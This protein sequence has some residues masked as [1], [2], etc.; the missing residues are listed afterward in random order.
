MNFPH[1]MPRQICWWNKQPSITIPSLTRASS[2][3][4]NYIWRN[5]LLCNSRKIHCL[6]RAI[7]DLPIKYTQLIWR[8]FL[9]HP[10]DKR[11][12]IETSLRFGFPKTHV[13]DVCVLLLIFGI[14]HYV[15]FTNKVLDFQ[16]LSL[17][18]FVLAWTQE[19]KLWRFLTFIDKM[20]IIT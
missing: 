8:A 15:R 12:A 9:V 18:C 7:S 17:V 11:P 14:Q 4:P 10:K 5:K 3:P 16:S 6:T 2:W 19:A 1:Q 13:Q 20:A